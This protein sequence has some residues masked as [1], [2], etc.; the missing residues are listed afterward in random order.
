[1]EPYHNV[2]FASSHSSHAASSIPFD[3]IDAEVSDNNDSVALCVS[4]CFVLVFPAHNLVFAFFQ[5]D[6]R[7][8]L[9]LPISLSCDGRPKVGWYGMQTTV[10]ACMSCLPKLRSCTGYI[11]VCVC[12]LFRSNSR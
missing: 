10:N 8:T 6:F 1:M 7:L 11:C 3:L 2:V 9:G 12:V 5:R 4:V